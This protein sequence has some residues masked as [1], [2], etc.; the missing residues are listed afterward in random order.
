MSSYDDRRKYYNQQ[1]K[2]QSR[3]LTR[4]MSKAVLSLFGINALLGNAARG[5]LEVHNRINNTPADG[6]KQI[7]EYVHHSP[8]FRDK[9]LKGY[10]NPRYIFNK[11]IKTSPLGVGAAGLAYH[12]NDAASVKRHPDD[13]KLWDSLTPGEKRMASRHGIESVRRRRLKGPLQK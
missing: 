1:T 7:S 5:E 10:F 4:D 12:K 13:Q 8:F 2:H 11:A 3:E 9:R 6:N